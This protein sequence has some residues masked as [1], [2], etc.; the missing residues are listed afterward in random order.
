MGYV[1][2]HLPKTRSAKK[3]ASR[4]SNL[5][6]VL[7]SSFN[8]LS[9]LEGNKFKL[10]HR[11]SI[12]R[13]DI[14]ID[15]ESIHNNLENSHQLQLGHRKEVSQ[16]RRRELEM[17]LGIINQIAMLSAEVKH[18]D[19]VVLTNQSKQLSNQISDK[20]STLMQEEIEL[21]HDLQ[22]VS[23]PQPQDPHI[24]NPQPNVPISSTQHQISSSRNLGSVGGSANSIQDHSTELEFVICNVSN[25]HQSTKESISHL[26]QSL[27]ESIDTNDHSSGSAQGSK[28]GLSSVDEVN[29]IDTYE[30][31]IVAF[32]SS[33]RRQAFLQSFM[34]AKQFRR[35]TLCQ[36]AFHQQQRAFSSNS[37][38][39]STDSE[40]SRNLRYQDSSVVNCLSPGVVNLDSSHQLYGN[41]RPRVSSNMIASSMIR[42]QMSL[43]HSLS[44]LDSSSGRAINRNDFGSTPYGHD[45]NVY[46]VQAGHS[47]LISSKDMYCDQIMFS[48][49][50]INELPNEPTHNERISPDVREDFNQMQEADGSQREIHCSR[51]L[52]QRIIDVQEIQNLY[53]ANRNLLIRL[54]PDFMTLI[55]LNF[56]NTQQLT[57]YLTCSSQR[58]RGKLEMANSN[59]QN[60]EL[61]RTRVAQFW[62]CLSN[63]YAS[64]IALISL[65]KNRGNLDDST[66][67]SEAPY[68][69]SFV[70]V[71]DSAGDIC[72]SQITCTA[73]VRWT[74][75]PDES[76]SSC[77]NDTKDMKENRPH[78]REEKAQLEPENQLPVQVC[79]KAASPPADEQLSPPSYRFETDTP[80][81]ETSKS[82]GS[83]TNEVASLGSHQ[84]LDFLR[85]RDN[86]LSSSHNHL[87]PSH[88]MS[89]RN[90]CGSQNAHQKAIHHHF[91]T[92]YSGYH[93]HHHYHYHHGHHHHYASNPNAC[94]SRHHTVPLTDL[95]RAFGASRS[96]QPIHRSVTPKKSDETPKIPKHLD[97]HSNPDLPVRED[98][99]KRSSTPPSTGSKVA[100]RSLRS[101]KLLRHQASMK[102]NSI[103][104]KL[105]GSSAKRSSNKSQEPKKLEVDD[106]DSEIELNDSNPD[107]RKDD[108]SNHINNDNTSL[109]TLTTPNPEKHS[110]NVSCGSVNRCVISPLSSMSSLNS[111]NSSAT[112]NS[113]CMGS[114]CN[115]NLLAHSCS[116][117]CCD[118][119][120]NPRRI[121]EETEHQIAQAIRSRSATVPSRASAHKA[122]LS[123]LGL[124]H[125]AQYSSETNNFSGNEEQ[126]KVSEIFDHPA[127][128][129]TDRAIDDLDLSGRPPLNRN[130]MSLWL[131]CEDGSIIIIDCLADD[132]H[133][134]N[135]NLCDLN[136]RS[137]NCS[138]VHSELKLNAPICDIR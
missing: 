22:Y 11:F 65:I 85:S 43:P 19:T 101:A 48:P 88:A 84:S 105:V 116:V 56:L 106:N 75:L 122:D 16:T 3:K 102:T 27:P 18:V 112:M 8:D 94:A 15:N 36:N 124:E 134:S 120:S 14:R 7:V 126:V 21:M 89:L 46:Q 87:S 121:K 4:R 131:G 55:P 92:R 44:A 5:Q 113:I 118:R 81:S 17:D 99:D 35:Q 111:T 109:A 117:S 115:P 123:R 31:L 90:L 20:L 64:H 82:S 2:I 136:Q 25:G 110:L 93:G 104:A 57:L 125:N 45:L 28:V 133:L 135:C 130:D 68:R 100:M 119:A 32:A 72:K 86:A 77:A 12:D 47:T 127:D 41:M 60:S 71:I 67:A 66:K 107:Q 42:N 39:R 61:V 49:I 132:S 26:A 38:L 80:A 78:L 58:F 98:K 52:P 33:E 129:T 96:N 59:E 70:P 76:V 91:D 23:P 13:V 108:D 9:Q 103:I 79:I 37:A 10:L 24:M 97:G 137:L 6:S 69:G 53:Q 50:Q 138:N 83:G 34:E 63:G 54:A 30:S 74:K 1:K 95:R 51:D 114:D 62:I 73:K 29:H 40:V 128:E